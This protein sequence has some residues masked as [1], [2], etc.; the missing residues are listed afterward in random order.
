MEKIQHTIRRAEAGDETFGRVHEQHQDAWA[1]AERAEHIRCAH[2]FAAHGADV[3]AACF[4]HEKARRDRT[5]EITDDR[6]DD[7]TRDVHARM[8]VGKSWRMKG[9]K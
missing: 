4:G 9:E 7:I 2:V 1:F 8:L 5:E 3:H 6:C